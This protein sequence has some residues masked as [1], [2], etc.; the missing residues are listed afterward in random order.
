[1][2]NQLHNGIFWRAAS[3]EA[4]DARD[5]CAMKA[6][7]AQA[8]SSEELVPVKGHHIFLRRPD[9]GHFVAF[10]P[11]LLNERNER[12]VQRGS[13]VLV[14]FGVEGDF[15]VLKIDV[16]VD[17]EISLGDSAALGHGDFETDAENVLPIIFRL[18]AMLDES[19]EIQRISHCGSDQL[20]F[21]VCN[22]RLWF[23]LLFSQ[24]QFR[25]GIAFQHPAVDGFLQQ[26]AKVNQIEH[27]VIVRAWLYTS[28]SGSGFAPDQEGEA[29]GSLDLSRMANFAIGEECVDILPGAFSA[30]QSI[31]DVIS[32]FEK[33]G[34]P[35]TE[36]IPVRTADNLR[37]FG[38][39][40]GL[41]LFGFAPILADADSEF[42]G[43]PFNPVRSRIAPFDPPERAVCAAI[44]TGHNLC[45]LMC[46]VCLYLPTKSNKI[47]QSQ[48]LKNTLYP[49]A[50]KRGFESLS[51]RHLICNELGGECASIVPNNFLVG[52]FFVLIF[53]VF[54]EVRSENRWGRERGIF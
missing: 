2:V 22:L 32:R 17:I 41:F 52:L 51:L 15:K 42:R 1:M 36:M 45:A 25:C 48:T 50:W 46:L 38:G 31:R 3:L 16:P 26:N 20:D 7:V 54:L 4:R 23:W 21:R 19:Y 43:E 6:Q 44:K 11:E 40:F 34:N 49:L 24:P 10:A 53:Q 13:V 37:F 33:D 47:E 8:D 9:V 27:G 35:L 14:A 28:L 39:K 12:R 5:A 18:R 30:S 29:V